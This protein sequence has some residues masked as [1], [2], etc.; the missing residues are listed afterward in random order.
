M[1]KEE[2]YY[3]SYS[4][5][6]KIHATKWVPEGTPLC[7]VQI[8]HGMAEHMGRYEEFAAFLTERNILVVG[9]DHLG[10][11]LSMGEN[12]PGYYCEKNPG[13]ALVED[14]HTLKNIVRAEYPDIPHILFGHSMGSF[15]ARNFVHTYHKEVDG[16][17]LSG[18][19]MLPK[20]LLQVLCIILKITT[21]VRGP[22]YISPFINKL[23]FGGYLKGIEN[24]KTESDWL[25]TDEAQVQMF[26]EDPLCG[27]SLTLNG[28]KGM[29]ELIRGLYDREKIARIDKEFPMYFIF[30][31][32]DPVGDFGKTAYKSYKMYSD[33]GMEKVSNRAYPGKRHEL[34]HEDIREKVM[35]DV[36]E[37]IGKVI[38]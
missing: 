12:P 13:K 15:I 9:E 26:L 21:A 35:Q 2:F 6:N 27:F 25:T 7:I 17:I 20:A 38:K 23:A 34:L 4:N 11:G 32:K 31:E 8:V 29:A 5:T 1:R 37:W 22:R 33:A 18:T 16:V 19:G 3:D 36:F 24:P 30:G 28:F 14:V 10:H